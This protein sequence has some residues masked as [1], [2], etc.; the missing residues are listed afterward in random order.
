MV[1][2]VN[3]PSP[4]AP[5]VPFDLAT[6]SGGGHRPATALDLDTMARIA[7]EAGRDAVRVGDA[8]APLDA[9][10][11]LRGI[12]TADGMRVTATRLYRACRRGATD[13]ATD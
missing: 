13:P 12:P 4:P 9:S 5:F 7:E 2:R 10:S 8:Q 11:A 6:V 3:T 1:I